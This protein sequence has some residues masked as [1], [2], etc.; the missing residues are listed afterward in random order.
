MKEFLLDI[1]SYEKFC[2]HQYVSRETF[3]KFEI[4]YKT[5][6]KWQK[7]VNL[8]SNSTLEY[9]WTRHF[10]DSAQ[11]YNF[12][13]KTHGNILD[14]GS[15][16][17]FPGIILAM[18]GNKNINV[19]E[20]DQKKCTF[21]R[22]VARLSNTKLTIH[23]SRIEALNFIES[24]LITSRALAPLKKLVEYVELHM[25][26]NITSKKKI[27]N[28]LFLKGKLYNDELTELKKTS[29]IEFEVHPSITSDYGKV[30]YLN[31]V[32]I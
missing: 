26:K 15:G 31:N 18:M 27:P 19:V 17:G 13:E 23:N 6:V 24:D 25:N 5:L 20:S 9:I 32:R 11:L 1:N 28:M 16:A 8:I 10:L 29:K 12:T 21:M 4:F 3:E 30:L 14:M 7:S 22:E 2:S